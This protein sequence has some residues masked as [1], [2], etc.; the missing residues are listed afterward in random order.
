MKEF[1]KN[2]KADRITFNS[3]LVS[4]IVLIVTFIVI[5]INYLSL[6]PYIP[7]FNQLPWGNERLTQTPGIFITTVIYIFIL[8]FNI[9]FASILYKKSNPLLGRVIASITLLL[10]VMNLLFTLRTIL[11]VI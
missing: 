4:F 8:L 1:I 5:A 9:G 7:I 6:P 10:S 11:L 3:F 2:I